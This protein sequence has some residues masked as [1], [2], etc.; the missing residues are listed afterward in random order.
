M[1]F[2]AFPYLYDPTMLAIIDGEKVCTTLS[3]LDLRMFTP[4]PCWC[5]DAEGG[6]GG[7]VALDCDSVEFDKVGTFSDVTMQGA[8]RHGYHMPQDITREIQDW[9]ERFAQ[10]HP[11]KQMLPRE[12]LTHQQ[13]AYRHYATRLFSYNTLRDQFDA[14][15][16]KYNRI[17]H[18][19][20]QARA[21]GDLAPRALRARNGR[22]Q[23]RQPAAGAP[24]VAM[25]GEEQQD[26]LFDEDGR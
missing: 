19:S 7:W 21:G 22:A 20:A 15:S 26:S 24:D 3:A 23:G 17:L 10:Q 9:C 12:E 18:A 14:D 8:T 1:L 5:P 13:N 11:D 6:A 16:E 2:R 4:L 25:A